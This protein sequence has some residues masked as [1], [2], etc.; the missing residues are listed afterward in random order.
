MMWI[1]IVRYAVAAALLV[2]LGAAQPAWATLPTP[3]QPIL[4]V[5]DSNSADPYQNFVPELLTTEGLNGFQTAQ[6]PDLTAAFLANYDVVVLP[7]L[8][9]TSAQATLFQNYVNAGGTLIG[10]RPDLQLANVFGVASLGTTLSEGWLKIDTTTAYGS[11]LDS[12][13]MRFHGAADLYSLSGASSLATLYNSSTLPTSSPAAAIYT[14]GSGKAIPPGLVIPTIMTGITPC[15]PRRCSWTRA[16]VN[17]GMTW[18]TGLSMM[19][20]RLTFRCVCSVMP[21][22]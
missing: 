14:F 21:W 17:F 20:L 22:Y 12:S 9:L 5:Q 10:F 16:Q 13:V 7:H 1:R 19:C 3:S 4:A 15:E 11:G 6:L 2:L 18:A 8:T